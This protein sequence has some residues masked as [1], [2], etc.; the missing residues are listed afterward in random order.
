MKVEGSD[1]TSGSKSSSKARA[2]KSSGEGVFD[3]MIDTTGETKA[4]TP[5]A[6]AASVGALDSL[7][8]LQGEEGS[9][10]KESKAGKRAFDLLE[11]LEKIRLG[12]LTGTLPKDVLSQLAY[13]VSTHREK[14]MDPKLV[15]IL[16]EIDLRAQVELAKLE[17]VN[18]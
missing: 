14:V 9:A 1:K 12:L 10:S 17:T 13:T 4:Q 11:H 6:C 8:A 7:L 16:D 5:V 18:Y 3:S 2:K 15:E